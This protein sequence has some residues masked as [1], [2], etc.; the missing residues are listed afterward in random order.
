MESGFD[1]CEIAQEKVQ[2][3]NYLLE[4]SGVCQRKAEK[5]KRERERDN[6]SV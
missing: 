5:E 2:S 6:F 3:W 4:R 1:D